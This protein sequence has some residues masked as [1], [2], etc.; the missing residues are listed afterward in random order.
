MTEDG[1]GTKRL[2]QDAK[3]IARHVW[4]SYRNVQHAWYPMSAQD[5][6]Q[7]RCGCRVAP[8]TL[9]RVKRQRCVLCLF[10]TSAD[11]RVAPRTHGSSARTPLHDIRVVRDHVGEAIGE[12]RK[13]GSLL[14][15]RA[16]LLLKLV[17]IDAE[18][19]RLYKIERAGRKKSDYDK[20]LRED[21][22]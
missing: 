12:L 10:L 15:S 18:L 19:L 11:F 13:N 21:A 9:S 3:G 22:T 16:I 2:L 1:S 7:S 6:R 4:L 20:M 17:E 14:K 5:V 8:S